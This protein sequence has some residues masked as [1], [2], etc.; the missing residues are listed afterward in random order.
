MKDLLIPFPELLD[1]LRQILV[2]EGFAGDEAHRCAELFAKTDLDGVRSHG[3]ERFGRFLSY[4]RQGVVLMDKKPVL[5]SKSGFFERWDGQLGSGNLNAQ[6]AM[7]RAMALASEH[8]MGCVALA[9]T[10]HWMRGGSYGWQAVEQGKIGLCFTNT[11]PNMPAWDAKEARLG[12]NPLVIAIPRKNGPAVLDM[13]M[14]QFAYGKLSRLAATGQTTDFPAGFNE[15]GDLTHDPQVVLENQSALPMGM[16][17]GAGLSL[18]IDLLAA[19]LSGGDSVS[20]IGKKPLESSLSQV[21]ISL[22]PKV[23][24]LEAWFADKAEAIITDY[25]G[26]EAFEGK[27]VFYPGQQTL[28]TR[29]R[30][31]ENGV[32]VAEATWAQIINELK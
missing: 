27:S 31:L 7:A 5:L 24:G 9:H 1:T 10:N 28:R 17:K 11:M 30:N 19:L 15:K 4:I 8:G 23:L 18:M 3:V 29:K 21:F 26:A 16:W 14:S 22:D 12:N 6:A 25:L 32:P 13:A 2:R 20:G